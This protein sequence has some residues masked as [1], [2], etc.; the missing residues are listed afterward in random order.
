MCFACLA[1]CTGTSGFIGANPDNLMEK[2]AKTELQEQALGQIETDIPRGAIKEEVRQI[3]LSGQDPAEFV[4]VYKLPQK[5]ESPIPAN[6]GIIV[7]QYNAESKSWNK[8]WEEKWDFVELEF[9]GKNKLSNE[10][11][12]VAIGGWSGNGG[13]FEF[14]LLGEK[15]EKITDLINNFGEGLLGGGIEF[16]EK[17]FTTQ[18]GSQGTHYQW[19]GNDFDITPVV[20]VPDMSAKSDKDIVLHYSFDKNENGTSNYPVDKVIKMQV[21]Q[22]LYLVRDNSNGIEERIMSYGGEKVVLDSIDWGV[23]EAQNT[24][25]TKITIIPNGYDW[26]KALELKILVTDK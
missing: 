5:E 9:M 2:P 20:I 17:G 11:E 19:N 12:Q 23:F 13:Y 6:S 7:E 15:D 14:V 3:A 16:D 26:D 24:G 4:V 1:G 8:A 21:G 25:E 10:Q 22:K 18:S